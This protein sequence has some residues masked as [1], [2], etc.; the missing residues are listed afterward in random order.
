MH[1]PVVALAG[2]LLGCL[3]VGCGGPPADPAKEPNK[4]LKAGPPNASPGELEQI[5]QHTQKQPQQ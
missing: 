3:L 5:R 2:L 1:T 4:D